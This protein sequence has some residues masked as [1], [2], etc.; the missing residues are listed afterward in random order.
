MLANTSV[1]RGHTASTKRGS[2]H[3]SLACLTDHEAVGQNGQRI[4]AGYVE[5]V[6]SSVETFSSKNGLHVATL[7]MTIQ[8]IKYVLNRSIIML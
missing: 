5:I 2:A 1:V 7:H 4:Y 3:A 6:Q 8:D